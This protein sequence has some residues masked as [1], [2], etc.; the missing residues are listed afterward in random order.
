[1]VMPGERSTRRIAWLPRVAAY[2]AVNVVLW[3]AA[4]DFGTL[5]TNDYSCNVSDCAPCRHIL[6]AFWVGVWTALSA[7]IVGYLIGR[8]FGRRWVWPV[9][10]A[11]GIVIVACLV[12]MARW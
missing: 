3:G 6:T 2:C 10:G 1:M 4:F 11:A 7:G 8:R 12:V 9:D 5:C